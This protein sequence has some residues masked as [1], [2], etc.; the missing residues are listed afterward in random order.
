MPITILLGADGKDAEAREKST[1]AIV[2]DFEDEEGSAVIPSEAK[3]TLT[4]DDGDVVD[5]RDEIEISSPA[6]SETVVLKGDNL[7]ILPGEVNDRFATRRFLVE[8]KYSSSLGSGLPLNE[9][10]TF[11]IRNLK[12]IS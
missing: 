2:I 12:H 8:A 4:N 7:Q 6:A 1:I 9:S 11:S 5:T 10:C 3:W